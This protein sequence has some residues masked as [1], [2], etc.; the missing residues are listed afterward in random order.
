MRSF[1]KSLPSP[2]ESISDVNVLKPEITSVS[3]HSYGKE[4][5]IT[6][7]GENLWFCH[8]VKVASYKQ[9]VTVE[10]TTQKSLQFNIE[11]EN[12]SG[13]QDYVNVK[14]WNHFSSPVVNS[15]AKVK[16]KVYIV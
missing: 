1:A 10:N 4:L 5:A 12:F 15:K 7:T 8:Q 16:H 9:F 11:K 6:V 2:N 3:F 13:T 14:V